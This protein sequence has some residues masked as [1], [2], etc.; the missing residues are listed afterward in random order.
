MKHAKP[1]VLEALEISR[2]P[3]D[4]HLALSCPHSRPPA[5]SSAGWSTPP[6]RNRS[7]K[8]SPRID[9]CVHLKMM[10]NLVLLTPVQQNHSVG[11]AA[12]RTPPDRRSSWTPQHGHQ[13]QRWLCQSE[14]MLAD[15]HQPRILLQSINK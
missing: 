15:R 1:K 5:A 2:P 11:H 3:P 9:T 14:L 8:D 7:P 6:L 4:H 12:S 13:H 10:E